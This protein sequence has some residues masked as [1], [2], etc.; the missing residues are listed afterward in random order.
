M[1]GAT[2]IDRFTRR[3]LDVLELLSRGLTNKQMATE[4]FIAPET[5]KFHITG[6]LTKTNSKTRTE[7]AVKWVMGELRAFVS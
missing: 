7:L 4:L 2:R 6:L 1:S 5:V 3:E